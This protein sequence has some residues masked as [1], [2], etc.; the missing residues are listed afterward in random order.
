M[1]NGYQ[2]ALLILRA[3]EAYEAESG[4]SLTRFRLSRK[5]LRRIGGRT[6]LR[7]AFVES[8]KDELVEFGWALLEVSDQFALLRLDRVDT[9]QRIAG[10]RISAEIDRALDNPDAFDFETLDTR[11]RPQADAGADD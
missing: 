9:W 2:T 7:D 6:N 1:L 8:V 10:G 4:R 3:H 5:S 11:F